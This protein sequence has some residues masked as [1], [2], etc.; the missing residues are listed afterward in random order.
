MG[1]LAA[2]ALPSCMSLVPDSIANPRMTQE[3]SRGH[4]WMAASFIYSF[5]DGSAHVMDK[6]LEKMAADGLPM[7]EKL[8]AAGHSMTF[9]L[10]DFDDDGRAA[11][12]AYELELH[13][14]AAGAKE[15]AHSLPGKPGTDPAAYDAAL[16]P[17][18]EATKLDGEILKQGH[19]A[20]YALANG[21]T[22]LNATHDSL[23][24]HAFKLLLL[25]AKLEKGE[26]Q[27]DWLDP[28]RPAEESIADIDL[29]LR[30]IEEDH[31]R[32]S[33]ERADILGMLAMARS[34]ESEGAV[35]L[36]RE[37]V[38]SSRARAKKW[39]ATHRRPTADDFGVRPATLPSAASITKQLTD[40]IGFVGSLAKVAQG[41]LTANPSKALEG[42]AEM[43]PED[44]SAK[45]ALDGLAAAA[46]GDVAGTVDAISKLTEADEA[47]AE[48]KG[49]LEQ[50]EAAKGS[51]S[52]A[53]SRAKR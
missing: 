29:A 8:R 37:Q 4:A 9:E 34:Y 40:K 28:N 45:V 46:G 39:R 20:L 35:E 24:K 43:A 50:L 53:A 21:M 2:S 41:V 48:V 18:S 23:R 3:G 36:L 22:S 32:Q 26:K 16:Q 33:A 1:L 51:V 38:A 49:R 7:L 42:L 14:S 17:A 6:T 47:V 5:A 27:V 31:E 52:D 19:F 25:R 11:V 30:L 44:S 10:K 13:V 15:R 12:S